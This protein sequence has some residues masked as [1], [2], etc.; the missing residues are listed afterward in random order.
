MQAYNST[1]QVSTGYTPFM[2]MHSRCEN[3]DLPL[4]LL[5]TS[6]RPDLIKRNKIGA[7]KYMVEQQRHMTAIHDVVS[8]HLQSSAEMQQRGQIQVGLKMREFKVGEQVW[9]YYPPTAIKNSNTHGPDLLK[10]LMWPK[11]GIL[12]VSED[13]CN[14]IATGRYLK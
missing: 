14:G 10:S 12:C 11:I 6:R 7:A 2:L 8:K 3:P 4:D 5:Y 1:V 13:K 9:W